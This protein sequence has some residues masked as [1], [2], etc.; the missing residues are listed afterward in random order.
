MVNGKDYVQGSKEM[1]T[2]KGF[3]GR[4]C[5]LALGLLAALVLVEFVVRVLNLYSFPADDFVETH[6]ELGWSHIP[7]KEGYWLVEGERIPIRINSKGLRDRE[8]SYDKEKGTFRILVLG[9]SF[10]QALQVALEDTFCKVLEARLNEI[11]GSFE[12]INGGFGGVGTDYQLLFLRR[13]GYKYH[14]D[15]VIIAFFP[16]DVSDNYRSKRV[17]DNDEAPLAYEERGLV[18]ELKQF[19][20]KNSCAYNYFGYAIPAHFPALAK[21]LMRIGLLSSQPIDEAQGVDQRLVLAE[22]YGPEWERA[23]EVTRA[24][25]LELKE[26]AK[27]HGSRMALISIPFVQQVTE[28]RRKSESSPHKPG[29]GHWDIEKPD[30]LLAKFLEEEDIPFLPLLPHFVEEAENVQFYHGADGHWNKPGHG[31]AAEVIY[32]WLVEEK[33]IPI[34]DK[35]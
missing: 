24:L 30:R 22:R 32:D 5:L 18:V 9:D 35:G 34:K 28:G 1:R 25:V 7:N 21:I 29:T 19:L 3:V 17:L 6:P 20:A 8:Y 33:L 13:E 27:K 15:L 11:N 23:W 26:V 14:P 4:C 16:N 10:T 12:V 31:L 2:L